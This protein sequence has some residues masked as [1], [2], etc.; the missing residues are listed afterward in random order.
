[1]I[2]MVQLSSNWIVRCALACHVYLLFVMSRL[3]HSPIDFV[4]EMI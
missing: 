1:M 4:S 3:N 2:K